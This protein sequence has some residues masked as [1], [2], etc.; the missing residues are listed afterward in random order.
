MGGAWDKTLWLREELEPKSGRGFELALALP[1][2]RGTGPAKAVLSGFLSS[3]PEMRAVNG[4]EPGPGCGLGR[5]G[6]IVGGHGGFRSLVPGR[7]CPLSLSG[8]SL[9]AESA[10]ESLLESLGHTQSGAIG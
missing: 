9:G 5:R 7:S 6:A 10:S 8:Q 2:G 3:C 4:A 1:S